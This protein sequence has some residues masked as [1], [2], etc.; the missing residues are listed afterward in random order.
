M[1]DKRRVL[2]IGLDPSVLEPAAM[3]GFDAE[4]VAAGIRTAMAE[5][6]AAGFD[7]TWC[8]VDR[9]ETAEQTVVRALDRTRPACVVIGAGLR[10]S[11][12]H[13]ELFERLL[14][15]VHANAPGAK[16]AFNTK[17]TDTLDAVRRTLGG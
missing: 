17:P 5:L 13:F 10:V 7:A 8:P 1:P 14:N 6:D 3:P 12:P 9:G 4:V 2:Y 15:A 16:I 11:P